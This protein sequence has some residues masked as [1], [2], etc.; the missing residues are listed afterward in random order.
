LFRRL[1][2]RVTGSAVQHD[3]ARFSKLATAVAALE[4]ELAPSAD[5]EL[6]RRADDLRQRSRDGA[7]PEELVVEAFAVAREVSRRALGLRPYDVQVV[8]AAGLQAGR[9]VEAATGEGKTLAAVLAAFVAALPGR[10]VHVLTFNDYLAARDAAWMGPVYEGLGLSVGVVEQDSTPAQRRSA[11]A[12]DITYLT[13][14]EAGFDLLRDQ[15]CLSLREQVQR[16]LHAV[17]VDEADSLLIDEARIPL[18]I[19]GSALDLPVAPGRALAAVRQL[20]LER[21]YEV[22]TTARA[23]SLTEQGY[24]RA[25]RL[26]G[27]ENLHAPEHRDLLVALH[28]ALQAE[29]LLRRDVDY[30]VRDDRVELVDEFTGRVVQ[31]RRWPDGLQTALEVKEGL[32]PQREGVVLGSI[33]LQHFIRL[34]DHVAGMTATA[35]P[36]AQE[37][38]DTYGL[39]TLVVPPNRPCLREDQPDRVFVDRQAKEAA[40]EAEIVQAHA[41]GRPVLVG[42][43]SVQESER[44]S[45]RLRG[46]DVPHRVLNARNDA[47]EAEIVAEAG[48]PSAVT[49]STNMAGRGTDIRLGGSRELD[50]ERA[51]EVGG[52]YVIGTNRHASRRVDDQLRG[53]AGRQGDPGS[54][55]FYVCFEDPLFERV[56]PGEVLPGGKLPAATPA[57][58]SAPPFVRAVGQAQRI[59]E[60]QDE[61]L[62]SALGTFTA[63]VESQRH[64]VAK[65]RQEL[66]SDSAVAPLL[67]EAAPERHTAMLELLGTPVLAQVEQRT[68][69]LHLD[70]L[71]ADHLAFVAD[72]REGMQ[73]T[74]MAASSPFFVA[75]DP[76]KVF[77]GK[78]V[79]SFDARLAEV[80]A[81]VV[82]SL[83]DAS[84]DAGALSTCGPA[85]PGSTWTYIQEESPWEQSLR[86][87]FRG[88]KRRFAKG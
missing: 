29:T 72:L 46:L 77:H 20:R 8:A 10:G 67:L 47:E 79:A 5:S 34:Y 73:I 63:M 35:Q 27:C 2:A 28:L 41:A 39:Q 80:P 24:E 33:A 25:E 65:R 84:L 68:H 53:R 38:L 56:A 30:I 36:A 26:L 32:S 15:R 74:G 3:L 86:G 43:V 57:P 17:I 76:V 13:A 50:R 66:L 64:V 52:L 12:C 42:T 82:S 85:H 7:A 21:D 45:A 16:G 59:V 51:L 88:L 70:Q 75:D 44:L 49:I 78:L 71:W 48:L 23:A 58:L 87:F 18:V 1:W 9:V 14:R 69:L 62:R 11:Y 55:C 22:D 40:L 4:P 61:S 31:H 54:S 6:R 60:G 37:L 83:C 81:A 19:A